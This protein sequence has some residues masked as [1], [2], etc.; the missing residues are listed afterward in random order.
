MPSIKKNLTWDEL[1]ALGNPENA[2][3]I[4]EKIERVNYSDFQIKVH[5]EKKGR[6]GKEAIIIKGIDQSEDI[7]KDLC[8]LIKGQIGVGGS[9]KDGEILL[10]GSQRDKV[11]QILK[12]QGYKNIKKAGG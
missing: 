2:P 5:Y 9:V 4:P 1:Q 10:Q 6:G 7:L 12:D 8:K 11:I 3:E